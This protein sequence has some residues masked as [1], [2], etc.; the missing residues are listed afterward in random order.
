MFTLSDTHLEHAQPL[1]NSGHMFH[2]SCDFAEKN[3]AS[4]RHLARHCF[5]APNLQKIE[6]NTLTATHICKAAVTLRKLLVFTDDRKVAS[7]PPN[8]AQELLQSLTLVLD[9][10]KSD[11]DKRTFESAQS[12]SIEDERRYV[13]RA[14]SCSAHPRLIF[15]SS[16]SLQTSPT[17]SLC[18]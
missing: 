18:R 11:D 15:F 9:V 5:Y 14:Q 12:R 8:G 6:G 7:E 4:L 10:V 1:K 17:N 3:T 16:W 13:R 2:F